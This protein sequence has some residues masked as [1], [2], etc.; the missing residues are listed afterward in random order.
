MPSHVWIVR[1]ERIPEC[2]SGGSNQPIATLGNA[3]ESFS[4]EDDR[5]GQVCGD[6]PAGAEQLR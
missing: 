2:G 6:E 3:V 4:L 1:D 5:R